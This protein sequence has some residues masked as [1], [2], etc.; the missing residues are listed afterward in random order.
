M[1][2]FTCFNMKTNW[3]WKCHNLGSVSFSQPICVEFEESVRMRRTEKEC[4]T[5]NNKGPTLAKKIS[6]SSICD[7]SA[8]S[9]SLRGAQ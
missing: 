8:T 9:Q 4:E 6:N 3:S 2:V 7:T 1:T 5:E